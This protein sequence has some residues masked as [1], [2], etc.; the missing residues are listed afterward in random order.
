VRLSDD[1][2]NL[3]AAAHL[4]LYDLGVGL[5]PSL[6][7]V[8][9][10]AVLTIGFSHARFPRLPPG[11]GLIVCCPL[12]LHFSLDTKTGSLDTLP[13]LGFHPAPA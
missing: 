9:V 10:S 2:L 3:S 11:A 1:A 5:L 4:W 8:G 13:I 12:F 7:V 6:R